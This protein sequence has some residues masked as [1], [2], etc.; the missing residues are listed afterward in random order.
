MK[1]IKNLAIIAMSLLL[2]QCATIISGSKQ[3][4]SFQSNP[5]AATIMV[6]GFEIGKTPFETKLV[7]NKEHQVK[8]ILDGYQPYEVTLKRKFNAWYLGNILIGGLI[9]IIIDPVT[10]AI[11][12]LSPGEV[13]A[14]MAKGVAFKNSGKDL[15]ITVA[16]NKDENRQKIGQ[17]QP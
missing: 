11:Y 2:V 16:L 7:R 13:K 6:N 5:S 8:I 1:H 10:G 3:V 17:L 4:V 14:E 9:G 15:F 12:R